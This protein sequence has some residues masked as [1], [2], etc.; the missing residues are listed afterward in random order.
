[1]ADVL[2]FKIL[3]SIAALFSVK[4]NPAEA[5]LDA[6][7]KAFASVVT[8]EFPSSLHNV[9]SLGSRL[10]QTKNPI[11]TLAHSKLSRATQAA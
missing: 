11:K 9:S 4:P 2:S 8:G 7:H 6:S 10:G 3:N 5:D 1:M